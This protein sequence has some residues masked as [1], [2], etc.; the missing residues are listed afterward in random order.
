MAARAIHFSSPG[1][2]EP[3]P[4]FDDWSEILSRSSGL[5]W[6]DM[7]E[8]GE[9]EAG[10][11]R[12][13][14]MHELIVDACISTDP[15]RPKVD[16][17]GSH[18]FI[19]THGIDY[20]TDSELVEI[21]ELDVILGARYL[22]TA[23]HT[24]LVSI[25]GT[26]AL[27]DRDPSLIPGS[28]AML[29]HSVLQRTVQNIQP[30]IDAMSD[31]AD[32][33]ELQALQ[34]P[35]QETLEAIQKLK[36]SAL[37][38]RRAITP[39]VESLG[40]LARFTRGPI[41]PESGRFFEDLSDRANRISES[42]NILRERADSALATY[43]S[44]VGIQQNQA[45]KTLAVIATIFFPLSLIAGIYGMNFENIPELEW[46]YGYFA[47]VGMMAVVVLGILWG[48]WAR[49]YIKARNVVRIP[50]APF[51]AAAHA[52]RGQTRRTNR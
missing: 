23:H 13:I 29:A 24:R 8:P 52:V 48:F 44:T 40:S 50:V 32:A 25:D 18:L 21:A 46:E 35:R 38:L 34:N 11:L 51:A 33:V 1:V 26:M 9:Q 39:E 14:G 2:R 36:R 42:N 30:T 15:R 7:H 28:A 49:R 47:V 22:I 3:D 4:A 5:L 10:W 43:L 6:I 20:H 12:E 37:R 17:H 31:L 27:T 19:V 45:M 41:D 16:D